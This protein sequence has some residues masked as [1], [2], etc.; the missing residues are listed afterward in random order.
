MD[1]V[2]ARRPM[3]TVTGHKDPDAADDD[4][5]QGLGASTCPTLDF[6]TL[7]QA[8]CDAIAW[9]RGCRRLTEQSWLHVS[10]P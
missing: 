10:S 3:T 5:H 6:G 9:D 1:A 7:T 4:A 2:A 8:D